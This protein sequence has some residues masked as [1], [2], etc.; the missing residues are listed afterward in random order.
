VGLFPRGTF[1]PLAFIAVF[2]DFVD[3]VADFAGGGTFGKS[4]ALADD[5]F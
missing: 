4:D 1:L 3:Q 2:H 5:G